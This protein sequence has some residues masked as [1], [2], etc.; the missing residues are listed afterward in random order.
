[1]LTLWLQIPVDEAHQM[2]VFQGGSHF[3]SVKSCCI[4]VDTFVR[5]GL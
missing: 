1:M 3:S 4:L 5:S 2:E